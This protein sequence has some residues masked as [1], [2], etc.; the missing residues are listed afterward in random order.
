MKKSLIT[1]NMVLYLCVKSE[2]T[3]SS[4]EKMIIGPN[5]KT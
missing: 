5:K 4:S 3:T 1:N 2:L